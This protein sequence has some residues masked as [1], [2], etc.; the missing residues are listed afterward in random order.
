MA[1]RLANIGYFGL[2]KET[3]KGTPV[4]PDDFIRLFEEKMATS[5]NFVDQKPIYG[6]KFGTYTT[7]QGQRSH[8]GSVTVEAEPNTAAKLADMLLTRTSTT[9]AGPYTHV[10][11]LSNTTNPNS[12]T[13]DISTGNV[14]ARYWGVEASKLTPNWNNNEMQL[15]LDIA[16]LG[17]FQGREI[18][19]VSTNTITLK[20]DYDPV[21]NKGLVATD[22]VR[23]YKQS[24]GA[25]LDT[26]VTTVNA[27]GITVVLG[28]SA[29]AFAAG[30]MIYLR[31][32][33][34][35]FT[36]QPVF[37]WSKTFFGTGATASAALT[38]ATFAN[39]LRVEQ[40]STFEIMHNFESEG[41]ARSGG[42]DPAALVR[43]TGEATLTIKRFF[44]NPD[45]ITLFNNLA[46]TAWV[47]EHKSGSTNQYA[48]RITF[49]NVKTDGTIVPDLSSE[50]ILYSELQYHPNYDTSDAQAV[51]M[52]VI[53]NLSSI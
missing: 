19:T 33:T 6:N 36:S 13:V 50:D 51:A 10:F 15:Q 52:T 32:A 26:T 14:V 20:T 12:Y 28:A 17:S 18:A 16:A 30:D 22:L 46:K 45:D 42:F 5:G 3:T 39:Q 27:D 47:I 25:T 23:V 41:A 31:P 35:T 44:D 43:T 29:A 40:G 1:E 37:L 49:N 53:N 38:N 34:I 48:L 8:S 21:P 24:T 9:G 11:G 7:L 2:K 4:I